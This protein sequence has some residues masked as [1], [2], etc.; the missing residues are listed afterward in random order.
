MTL[1]FFLVHCQ[2][3]PQ[4]LSRLQKNDTVESKQE[5]SDY[6]DQVV[7]TDGRWKGLPVFL[8][9]VSMGGATAL[10]MARKKPEAYAG[11]ILYAP[12]ISFLFGHGRKLDTAVQPFGFPP[13]SDTIGTF[14][15]PNDVPATSVHA[16]RLKHG[17][18][19]GT[20]IVAVFDPTSTIVPLTLYFSSP[21]SDDKPANTVSS[22]VSRLTDSSII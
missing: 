8:W 7:L 16:S 4:L 6:L 9:S 15:K 18:S 19:P 10:T 11:L 1:L 5:A 21:C 13:V 12:M 2:C 3:V 17:K 20:A 22:S 14:K